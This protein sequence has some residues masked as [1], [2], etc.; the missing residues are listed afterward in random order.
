[1]AHSTTMRRLSQHAAALAAGGTALGVTAVF[2]AS[3]ETPP[4]ST[5]HPR[6]NDGWE[7]GRY[8]AAG[9]GFH[10]AEPNIHLVMHADRILP[11]GSAPGT[12][13]VL[14]PLCGKTV[15]MPFIAS[16]GISVVGLEGASRAVGEFFV[17]STSKPPT[18]KTI[19][20]FEANFTDD[21]PGL[22]LWLGDFFD[23]E[24]G[25]AGTCN[26]NAIREHNVELSLKMMGSRFKSPII[27]QMKVHSPQCG[28]AR[29]SWRSS[30]TCGRSE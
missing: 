5:F 28:T 7:A 3:A 4:A 30:P 15:D 18:K 24:V 27:L 22:E 9:T 13:R 23:L 12:A 25:S 6:W 21:V 19:G 2:V 10:R 20:K 16:R 17:E 1:M 11:A 14:V 8:S 26:T 29:A